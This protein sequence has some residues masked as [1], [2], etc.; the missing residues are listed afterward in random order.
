MLSV[1]LHVRLT[2]QF[3]DEVVVVVVVADDQCPLDSLLTEATSSRT[4]LLTDL[5]Q[6][7]LCLKCDVVAACHYAISPNIIHNKRS[8]AN[9]RPF[10]ISLFSLANKVRLISQFSATK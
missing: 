9:F 2:V 1:S 5:E 4:N 7:R 10:R 6:R 3:R 8:K